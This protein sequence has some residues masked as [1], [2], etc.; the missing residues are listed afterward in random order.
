MPTTT[1]TATFAKELVSVEVAVA[2]SLTWSARAIDQGEFAAY[3]CASQWQ[4][5][6]R[7][8]GRLLEMRRRKCETAKECYRTRQLRTIQSEDVWA[9][10]NL[11]V[12]RGPLCSASYWR[13]FTDELS[14]A[15]A[16]MRSLVRHSKGSYQP[17]KQSASCSSCQWFVVYPWQ[18]TSPLLWPL[19]LV[20]I[21]REYL[22]L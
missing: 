22:T 20:C 15:L 1:T 18:P 11:G 10:L 12:L 7:A 19:H 16:V 5:C 13:F 14:H 4:G 21:Y 6:S 3:R 2:L 8:G 9:M 17:R